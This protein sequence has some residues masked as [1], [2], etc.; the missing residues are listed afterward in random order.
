MKHKMVIFCTVF[1]K[2]DYF[3]QYFCKIA[4]FGFIHYSSL[5]YYNK[6]ELFLHFE[7]VFFYNFSVVI[8]LYFS[9]NVLF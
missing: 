2:N 7:N 3:V 9:R 6:C 4:T 5:P 8:N 1:G